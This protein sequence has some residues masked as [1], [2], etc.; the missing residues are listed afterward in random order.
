MQGRVTLVGAGC[1]S[2]LITVRGLKALREADIVLADDLIDP[3][4]LAEVKDDAQV[5]YVGKRFGAHSATQDEINDLLI[6]ASSRAEKVVRL[7]GG[8]GFVFGR[9]GEEMIA[10]RKA[11]VPCEI[12]PGVTSSVAVP[13]VMGIPVTHRQAA[14]SFTVVTGHTADGTSESFEALAKLKGNIVFLMGLHAVPE[15]AE[16]LI[17]HGK[18]PD[19]PASVLSQGFTLRQTRITGTLATIGEKSREAKAPAIFITG[20]TADMDLTGTVFRPLD[21][22][23]VIVTGT[24]SLTE[25]LGN[26]LEDAGAYVT[27]DET[28]RIEPRPEAVPMDLHAYEWLVFTSANGIR[29]FFRT[30]FGRGGDIRDLADKKFAVIGTG[31]ADA[32]AEYGIR[33]DFIPTEYISDVFG[34]ELGERLTAPESEGTGDPRVLILRAV[35]GAPALTEELR[36][37]GVAYTECGIYD[38]GAIGSAG[39]GT[40]EEDC[41][42]LIFSSGSGVRAWAERTGAISANPEMPDCTGTESSNSKASE[43]TKVVCIGRSTEEEFR[44][45]SDRPCLVPEKHT[46]EGILECLIEDRSHGLLS[47]VH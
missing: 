28:L 29:I 20:P 42:Y 22:V 26:L 27:R 13:E 23:R 24:K 15:I 35:N 18:S 6:D 25:R 7:K 46:I 19:T 37:H 12:I 45:Y 32:L 40:R 38:T 47:D 41:D 34:R 16:K 5:I 33:A 39:G 2:G 9:G 31:T 44:K 10:L 11:G 21:R 1:G 14:R 36:K 17:A 3:A 4:L 8:D 43:R 30:Y